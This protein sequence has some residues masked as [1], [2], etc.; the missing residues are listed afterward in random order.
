MHEKFMKVGARV[1]FVPLLVW[2][3]ILAVEGQ[4]IK[5]LCPDGQ[6]VWAPCSD[7]QALDVACRREAV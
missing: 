5:V 4:K 3:E 1:S 7:V 2:C 6:Q